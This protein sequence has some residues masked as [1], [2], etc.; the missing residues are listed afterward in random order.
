MRRM[1]TLEQAR[2]LLPQLLLRAD[3]I[4]TL[5]ADLSD[6]QKALQRG[7]RSSLGGLPEM[8]AAEARLQETIDWFT[9]QGI[10]V[11]GLAPLIV[12]FPSE[13]DGEVQLLCWLE[14]ETALEWWHAPESGFLGRRRI[15]PEPS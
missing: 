13:Q 10:E 8:K 11:K 15:G 2:A 14:G 1:F 12:D 3:E 4:I 5:R 7:E 9:A 6:A